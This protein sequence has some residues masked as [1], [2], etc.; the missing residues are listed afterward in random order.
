MKKI[1]QA[2]QLP[3]FGSEEQVAEMV[4]GPG[5]LRDWK[6]RTVVLE[7]EGLPEIDQLM[8]GRYLPAV[9][10]FFDAR[11]EMIRQRRGARP[12]IPR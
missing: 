2:K 10:A 3:L 9:R 4:W 6:E 7:R 5:R 11:S 12:K 8:G 1:G